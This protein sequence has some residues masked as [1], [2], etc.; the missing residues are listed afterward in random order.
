MPGDQPQVQEP[1]PPKVPV[2]P[3]HLR[4]SC[5]YAIDLTKQ[6]LTFAAAAVAFVIGLISAGHQNGIFYLG[7]SVFILLLLG[8]SM[9]AGVRCL[10][11]IVG[12]MHTDRTYD[13]Y[14]KSVLTPARYQVLFL[15][16]GI[17]FL[18]IDVVLMVCLPPGSRSQEVPSAAISVA[19]PTP[20]PKSSEVEA[21]TLTG[22]ISITVHLG[23][24]VFSK[25]LNNSE[26]RELMKY[27]QGMQ[28]ALGLKSDES[29]SRWGVNASALLRALTAF[30]GAI[31][32]KMSVLDLDHIDLN[33][34]H[35]QWTWISS[36]P[37]PAP[38]SQDDPKQS[39]HGTVSLS[40]DTFFAFNSAEL[41]YN[42]ITEARVR[43]APLPQA[44]GTNPQEVRVEGYTDCIGPDE[45]N[46]RLSMR[47]AQAI[48]VW[49][50][51]AR[52]DL[53]PEIFKVC[54]HG[55]SEAT[56]RTEEERKKDRRVTIT[57][58]GL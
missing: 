51:K 27:L 31:P 44:L 5:Q 48:K 40:A 53:R 58:L 43:G 17:F 4:D 32:H 7:F 1:N 46:L 18:A 33:L 30:A 24:G 36:I 11:M 47:R 39:P 9:F 13:I 10:M 19:Q 26:I 38:Q 41:N 54:G 6:F 25:L 15:A 45:Y 8:A 56:G 52:D 21:N 57:I 29:N 28:G 35:I 34:D 37:A 3:Q 2:I 42:K 12:E 16:A 50:I 22:S 14:R 55:K 49:L 20:V 23:G